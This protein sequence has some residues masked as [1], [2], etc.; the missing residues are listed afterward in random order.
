MCVCLFAGRQQTSNSSSAGF[1]FFQL[2]FSADRRG[3]T[4]EREVERDR[5]RKI[6]IFFLLSWSIQATSMA[7]FTDLG[8]SPMFQQQVSFP[9]P[10][11]I[12]SQFDLLPLFLIL[13]F[14]NFGQC[15]C[16]L[17]IFG[18][19]AIEEWLLCLIWI[20]DRYFDCFIG[21]MCMWSPNWSDCFLFV[22]RKCKLNELAHLLDAI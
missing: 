14:V 17:S 2:S 15:Q 9:D 12:P 5:E 19:L 18:L 11:L 21:Y 7:A 22:S 16:E 10:H 3:S 6:L 8:D 20:Y 13:I 4:E 1:S